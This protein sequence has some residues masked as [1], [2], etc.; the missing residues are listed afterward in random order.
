MDTIRKLINRLLMGCGDID[1]RVE[2]KIV[3]RDQNNSVTHFA[4]LPI[5]YIGENNTTQ[6]C[7]E[8]SQIEWR[9]YK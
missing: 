3:R 4:V 1:E 5:S 9:D 6:I 7:V 8:E 2:V